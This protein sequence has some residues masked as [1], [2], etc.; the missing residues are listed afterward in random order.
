MAVDGLKE[1]SKKQGYV[2]GR[3]MNK[4]RVPPIPKKALGRGLLAYTYCLLE[5]ILVGFLL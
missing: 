5:L 4:R 3:D 2:R 1:E